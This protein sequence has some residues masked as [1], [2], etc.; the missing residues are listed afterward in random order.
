MISRQNPPVENRRLTR[1]CQRDHLTGKYLSLYPI[2]I[3]GAKTVSAMAEPML[4]PV[5]LPGL[6][7][8]SVSG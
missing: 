6:A 2:M 1:G 5:L 8:L 4:S 7:R 3:F